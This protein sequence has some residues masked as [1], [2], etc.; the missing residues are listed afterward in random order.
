[1]LLG[2]PVRQLAYIVDDVRAAALAHHRNFGS[3]PYYVADHIPLKRSRYRGADTVFDHSAAYGQW[4][5]VM[6]EFMCQH[7]DAP[8]A[9]HDMYP[10]GREG[11]HHVALIVK[12]MAQ[13]RSELES[14]GFAE[15]LYAEMLDGFEFIMFDARASYGHFIELY[16]STARLVGFYDMVAQASL[17]FKG[18]DVLRDIDLDTVVVPAR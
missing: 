6:I 14:C 1:M 15:A 16:E 8:S 4:G 3:G 18:E 17:N 12:S 11:F 9:V 2:Q 10:R 5:S 13:A 7:N